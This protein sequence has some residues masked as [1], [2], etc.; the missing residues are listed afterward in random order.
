VEMRNKR[1]VCVGLFC[2][3]ASSLLSQFLFFL[4]STNSI[5][6]L[7]V[8][9]MVFGVVLCVRVF[10]GLVFLQETTKVERDFLLLLGRWWSGWL[11]PPFS[12]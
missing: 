2:F 12:S 3:V 7:L 1:N 6:L 9:W 10:V 8:G 5:Y 11:S 4:P